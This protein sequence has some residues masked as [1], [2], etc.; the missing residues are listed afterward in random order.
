M[1][2]LQELFGMPLIQ[3][4]PYVMGRRVHI[5]DP[6]EAVS[7]RFDLTGTITALGDLQRKRPRFK[8]RHD[9][10]TETTGYV[11]LEDYMVRVT[12]VL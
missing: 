12:P 2:G 9:D 5:W 10:E 11:A 3:A 6:T 8:F 1:N 4:L 7:I